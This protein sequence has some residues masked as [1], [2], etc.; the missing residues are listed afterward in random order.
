MII[1]SGWGIVVPLIVIGMSFLSAFVFI[2][3]CR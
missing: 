3:L 2:R 1:W